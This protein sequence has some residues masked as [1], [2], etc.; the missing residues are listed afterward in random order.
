[1]RGEDILF[2]LLKINLIETPPHA[3][4]RHFEIIDLFVLYIQAVRYLYIMQQILLQRFIF[5][6]RMVSMENIF[7][8]DLLFFL[9]HPHLSQA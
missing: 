8:D 7:H 5:M 1:M 9:R 6:S 2:F 3:R 4:G